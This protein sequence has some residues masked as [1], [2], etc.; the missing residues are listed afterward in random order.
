MIEK[1]GLNAMWQHHL[2]TMQ[3][4]SSAVSRQMTQLG[5]LVLKMLPPVDRSTPDNEDIAVV[6][7]V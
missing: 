6:Y 2:N 5:G 3:T 1:Y 7:S 4:S